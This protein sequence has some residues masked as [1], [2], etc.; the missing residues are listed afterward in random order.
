[1]S[2]FKK[3]VIL[4]SC[5]AALFLSAISW[6][7]WVIGY[8]EKLENMATDPRCSSHVEFI[9][10]GG[11][12]FRLGKSEGIV[13]ADLEYMTAYKSYLK[14]IFTEFQHTEFGTS[15]D[16]ALMHEFIPIDDV[17]ITKILPPEFDFLPPPYHNL[18]MGFLSLGDIDNDEKD[19]F[20][21]SST[22]VR[23]ASGRV[24]YLLL[25]SRLNFKLDRNY[26]EDGAG[27][28]ITSNRW[29]SYDE[30][31]KQYFGQPVSS[32]DKSKFIFNRRVLETET[33]LSTIASKNKLDLDQN[34]SKELNHNNAFF[35][36]DKVVD[37]ID[38]VLNLENS[39]VSFPPGGIYSVI[40]DIDGDDKPQIVV[41]YRD[42][43]IVTGTSGNS[44]KVNFNTDE[45]NIPILGSRGDF[46]QDGVEDFWLGFPD[47]QV[48]GK[49][50][51]ELNLI[52]GAT[53]AHKLSDGNKETTIDAVSTIKVV[54]TNRYK[55][56]PNEGYDIPRNAGDIGIHKNGI[57]Y[58]LSRNAGDIDGDGLPD[59]VTTSHYDLNKRGIIY[60]ILS[61]DLMQLS[62]HK[63]DAP[64]V[65]RIMGKALSLAGIGLDSASDFDG[66]GMD[67]IVVGADADHEAGFGA[68]AV[69]YLSGRK[70][71]TQRHQTQ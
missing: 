1:M 4:I 47:K 57:G 67:D 12:I 53:L 18:T 50:V 69:Y 43:F 62:V 55:P 8:P 66:D 15:R 28:L 25:S 32:K 6:G 61:H 14:D 31:P 48:G 40:D 19:D 51:G 2:K 38:G 60:V 17:L 20:I 9:V 23:C 56:G 59:L 45:Y 11:R 33:I 29:K 49:F 71:V 46:D 63:A 64:Y 44:I 26:V 58:D 16:Q 7:M 52:N 22:D 68:G 24:D 13:A 10:S 39:V 65:I 35:Y 21:V 34:A 54:G 3:N 41:I 5:F 42:Q 70:I 27:V 36:E 37:I 30:T